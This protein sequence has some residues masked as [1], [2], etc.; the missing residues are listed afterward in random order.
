MPGLS[1]LIADASHSVLGVGPR[2]GERHGF[3]GLENTPL[4]QRGTDPKRW[5]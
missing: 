5:K 3:G 2:Q 4:G 1:S